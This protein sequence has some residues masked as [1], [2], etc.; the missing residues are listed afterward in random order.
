MKFEIIKKQRDFFAVVQT[1]C[2]WVAKKPRIKSTYYSIFRK[3]INVSAYRCLSVNVA[4]RIN[5]A[6]SPTFEHVK[7]KLV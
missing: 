7:L 5:R 2:R 6:I 1:S 4:T 3:L